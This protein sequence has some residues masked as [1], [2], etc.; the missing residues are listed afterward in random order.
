MRRLSL[1]SLF[2]FL[3]VLTPAWAQRT[4]TNPLKA[5]GP[6]PWVVYKDGWYYY[7][8]TVGNRLDLWRTRHMADLGTAD[9]KTVYTPPASGPY[10]KQLW[11]PEIHFLNGKWYIYFAADDGR[12]VNHRMWVLENA[13]ADP[14]QGEW[15]LKGKLAD[16]GDHWAI[17]LSVFEHKGKLFAIWSGWEGAINGRQDIYI[18]RLKNPWTMKG[19]RVRLSKPD[20]PW[21]MHG[22]VPEEWQKNGE[23]PQVLVNEG[24]QFLRK[25]KNLFIVYSANACWRDYCLGQLQ[26]DGSGSLLK[27]VNWRKSPQPV[28]VQAPENG[29][30]APGHNSFFKSPDGREDWILYHANPSET[31]GCGNKRAPHAQRF[32]WNPDGTPNFG[33]PLPKTPMP[34]PSGE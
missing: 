16:P 9:R 29:V 7:M 33:K 2:L 24:P 15:V 13:S 22:D 8:N 3:L 18:A 10:S 21:E 30:F 25:D 17:D 23:V 11:A 27:A 14:M 28:F 1:L 32:S 6:D 31:D 34:A 12:N 20:L 4:L 26:Y 5:S 19:D